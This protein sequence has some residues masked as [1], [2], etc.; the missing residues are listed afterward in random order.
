M[1]LLLALLLLICH[2]S[3]AQK[4]EKG[5]MV[6]FKYQQ[7][8]LDPIL[9]QFSSYSLFVTAPGRM[10][11]Q[12][13]TEKKAVIYVDLKGFKEIYNN[14]DGDVRVI[15]AWNP[16]KQPKEGGILGTKGS[17]ENPLYYYY[18]NFNTRV[19]ATIRDTENDTIFH[20]LHDR[21][22]KVSGDLKSS[23]VEAEKSW[24]EQSKGAPASMYLRGVKAMNDTLNERFCFR[25]KILP[26]YVYLIKEKKFAYP[27]VNKAAQHVQQ[28]LLN[29]S[30]STDLL[31]E[32]TKQLV[33]KDIQV[34]QVLLKE[35]TPQDKK[36]KVNGQVTNALK[37][38]LGVCYF[39]IEDYQKAYQS[40]KN[41]KDSDPKFGKN[42]DKLLKEYQN[43][44]WRK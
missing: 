43:M 42:L 41:V 11:E 40:L 35:S 37:W 19:S 6:E 38:N 2:A 34:F 26:A 36:S 14:L 5:D 28:V 9:Q 18:H 44:S 29:H 33:E 27:E 8:P 3:L 20:Y 7:P 24:R 21:T 23:K 10:Q 17:K 1:R 22:V 30:S 4:V 31:K 16:V 32:E 12:D 13:A 25:D 39:L 15:I